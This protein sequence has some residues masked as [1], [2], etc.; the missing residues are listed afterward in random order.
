MMQIQTQKLKKTVTEA[1]ND[2][3]SLI[4]LAVINHIIKQTDKYLLSS[5]PK[6]ITSFRNNVDLK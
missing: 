6:E 2:T 5:Q 4:L 1:D 3:Y